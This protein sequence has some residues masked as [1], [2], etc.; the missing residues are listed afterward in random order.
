MNVPTVKTPI[1]WIYALLPALAAFLFYLPVINNGLVN[2]D[3]SESIISNIH[4]RALSLQNLK[5]ML[6]TFYTGNWLPLTWLS[7]ALDFRMGGLNPK[8]FHLTNSIFHSANTFLVFL[9]CWKILR[10][11]AGKTPDPE[12]AGNRTFETQVALL[13]ALLFGLHPIHVE[14]VAWAT[15]RKDVLYAPFYLL[16]ILVY[17]KYAQA[18]ARK[19]TL[20]WACAGLYVLSFMAKPM[21][22]TLPLVFLVLDFWPLGRFQTEPRKSLVE[23]IPLFI[24]TL[25]AGLVTMISHVKGRAPEYIPEHFWLMNCCRSI[26]FYLYKMIAPFNL[27][28]LYPFPRN[29]DAFYFAEDFLAILAVGLIS[30]F[31]YRYAKKAPYFSSAWLYFL[32][33]LFPV[34]GLIQVGSQT[35]ADRYTYLPCLGPFL[36]LSAGLWKWLSPRRV[37]FT[38]AMA[39]LVLLLGFGTVKQIGVWKDSLSLWKC[40]VS[41]YPNDSG[42]ALTNLGLID[43]KSGKMDEA[44]DEFNR[45]TA[46]PPPLALTHNGIGTVLFYKG[47]AEEAVKEFK[48]ALTLDSEYIPSHRNLWYAYQNQGRY[49]EAL[50]E[51]LAVVKLDPDAPENHNSLGATYWSLKKWEEAKDAFKTAFTLEPQNTDYLL[52]LATVCSQEGKPDEAIEW[53]QKATTLNPVEPVYYLKLGEIYLSKGMKSKAIELLRTASNL[54]PVKPKV[55]EEL[56]DAFKKAGLSDLAKQYANKAKSLSGVNNK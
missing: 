22:V 35:A 36:L 54:N 28:P 51:I 40:V 25:P 16:G 56:V 39:L 14:S 5:W 32:A 43:V 52:N 12:T 48:Y 19:R 23:K 53:F 26:V 27:V 45:A 29:M 3:D 15:E 41:V 2:W 18:P 31:C 4:I 44:M 8:I 34:L 11:A 20:L 30:F 6:T 17:L 50:A 47:R 21:A 46:I 13:T 33:T 1:P 49:Q 37:Y 9:V 42:L 38:A 10:L 24:L 7:L 55:I